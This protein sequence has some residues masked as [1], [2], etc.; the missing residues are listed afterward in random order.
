MLVYLGFEG[1]GP[2]QDYTISSDG[3]KKCDD[4]RLWELVRASL[5]TAVSFKCEQTAAPSKVA[6]DVKRLF[7]AVTRTLPTARHKRRFEITSSPF[8]T[9][10]LSVM[11]IRRGG[12]G[13]MQGGL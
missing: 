1:L 2:L 12:W 6:S 8:E 9:F 10:P 7:R 3:S 4:H 5:L 11:N 13:A